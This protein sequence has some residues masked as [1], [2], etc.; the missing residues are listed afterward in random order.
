[1]RNMLE[2][3]FAHPSGL[4][5]RLGGILMSRSESRNDWTLSLISFAPDARSLEVGFGPGTLIAALAEAVPAGHVS[6]IDI[7]PVML[8]QATARNRRLVRTQRVHLQLGTA[9]ALPFD[10]VSFDTVVSANSIFF[11]PDQP[12]GIQEMHRVLKPGGHI[13]LILQPRWAK[14]VDDVKKIGEQYVTM[15]KE[16]GFLQVR[17]ALQPMRPVASIAVLGVK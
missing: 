17:S 11:W 6:G 9:E 14:S 16:G 4:L 15:L 8:R 13:A 12:A 3:M 2:T 5:G 7:S 10:D 1:M